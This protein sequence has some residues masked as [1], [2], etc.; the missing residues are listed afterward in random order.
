MECKGRSQLGGVK[1]TPWQ[2][3]LRKLDNLRVIRMLRKLISRFVSPGCGT[4]V[5]EGKGEG[6]G[7][8]F[9]TPSQ[10]VDGQLLPGN[11]VDNRRG[12]V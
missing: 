9:R 12:L 3:K 1:T 2:L 7:K 8:P 11:T 4:L 6:G 10:L 5:R